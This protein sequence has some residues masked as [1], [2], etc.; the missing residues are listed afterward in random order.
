[1]SGPKRLL[2]NPGM[3]KRRVI[4]LDGKAEGRPAQRRSGASPMPEKQRG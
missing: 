1:V 2:K 3:E 4:L